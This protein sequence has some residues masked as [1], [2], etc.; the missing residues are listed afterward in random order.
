MGARLR[1]Y[2]IL[3]IASAASVVVKKCVCV[4]SQYAVS[5]RCYPQDWV[6]VLRPFKTTVG[7]LGLDTYGLDLGFGLGALGQDLLKAWRLN[8]NQK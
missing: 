4:C 6:L 7:G 3:S 8:E 2:L 1:P 5:P